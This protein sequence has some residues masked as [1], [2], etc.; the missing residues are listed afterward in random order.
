MCTTS[1]DHTY[2]IL[3]QFIWF[4]F[5]VKPRVSKRFPWLLWLVLGVTHCN[6]LDVKQ[7]QM[8]RPI[9]LYAKWKL[10]MY[11]YRHLADKKLRKKCWVLSF[12]EKNTYKTMGKIGFLNGFSYL[13]FVYMYSAE[14]V[15]ST[16]SERLFSSIGLPL[17][18][19][20]FWEVAQTDNSVWS[21]G[22]PGDRYMGR[23]YS[24]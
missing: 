13:F 8:S 7:N 23:K 24:P 18:L 1:F 6:V 11:L 19:V 9:L 2:L 16:Y 15:L 5:D 4:C 10:S 3:G 20:F 21:F 12:V 17:F 14:I 22:R